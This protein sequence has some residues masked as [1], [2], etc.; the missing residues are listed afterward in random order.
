MAWSVLQSASAT[1]P[2][3]ISVAATFPNNVASG[4]KIIA[5]LSLSGTRTV[6]T[7]QDGSG[8]NLTQLAVV[9]NGTQQH[10][11]LYAM[12]TPAGD[13]G[14]KPTIT[15][16]FSAI[17]APS[18]LLI[19]EV[20]GLLA[21]NTSAMLDGTPGTAIGTSG[22]GSIGPPTFTD[23]A[24]NEYLVYL[25]G[26]D[27]G[28]LTYTP[29]AGYTADAN[30]VN[31]SST[32]NMV[33]SYKNSTGGTETGSYAISGTSC[34]WSVMMAAFQLA[35][36]GTAAPPVPQQPG[37]RNWRRRHRRH[38]QSPAAMLAVT[39]DAVGAG[40]ATAGVTSL[41]WSHTCRAGAALLVWVAVGAFPDT[42]F[43]VSGVTLDGTTNFTALG[44]PVHD[45][46]GS[47]AGFGQ[48]F[49]LTGVAAGAHTIAVTVSGGTP[50]SIEGNSVS[51][52]NAGSFGTPQ[53][54]GTGTGQTTATLTHTGS[55][56]TSVVAF[57]AASGH[58]LTAPTLVSRWAANVDTN[59]GAGNAAIQDI[60]GGGSLTGKWTIV[61]DA[62]LIQA[63][64]ITLAGT[65]TV[66]SGTAAL[67]GA[68]SMSASGVF[69]G[70]AGL[71]GQG[72]LTAAGAFAGA[73]ALSGSGSM[74]ASGAFAG[75]A[76]LSGAGSMSGTGVRTAAGSAAL[77]GTG[78][79]TATGAFAGSALLSGSGSLSATGLV[80]VPGAATLSGTG[81][82]TA[83]GAFAGS[84]PLAGTGTMTAAGSKTVPGAAVLAG[85]GIM[86]ATGA[87]AGAANLAGTGTL[88]ATGSKR[89]PGVA[90]MAGTG[91]MT[92]TGAFAGVSALAGTGT[93]S[94]TGVRTAAGAAI[95]AGV[96]SMTA[97]GV[98]AGSAALAGTGTMTAT[99]Q[100]AGAFSGTA[101]LAGAGSLTA[102]GAVI[103]VGTAPLSGS[104]A[105]SAAW[106]L[107]GTA[108][109]SG[110]G[111]MTAAGTRILH[112]T[113]A[114]AGIGS[115][116]AAG[117]VGMPFFGVAL[118]SGS[119][120][121]T[122]QTASPR[123][124]DDTLLGGSAV[125]VVVFA[126]TITADTFQAG[127][128]L[129]AWIY[130]GAVAASQ[131]YAG[132]GSPALLYG[133]SAS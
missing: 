34:Q 5:A 40:Q 26:D 25:Y 106:L 31:S 132:S 56:A 60:P 80:V 125:A 8:N 65:V 72:S 69:A 98:F 53:T 94:A 47:A 115:L 91:T 79:M 24:A 81:I 15:V 49:A 4:T 41:S 122:G 29:P 58:P 107:A 128:I 20:S 44:S 92:A 63:V 17:N 93:L 133:G 114:L 96:G 14:T 36:A 62:Y 129:P 78:T 1:N 7:V 86:T 23:T 57:G 22:S 28:P 18:S 117:T 130:D 42:A 119:G 45:N 55:A 51:Y 74:S 105:M 88:T 35:A 3:A 2:A 59:T 13:V 9:A 110:T 52:L 102:T 120:T 16:T 38:Q 33:T 75:T 123:P 121:M 101:T 67:D 104:G 97:A 116:S 127:V 85:T 54:V 77:A 37:N 30:G 61:S 68:G 76:P 10:T 118:L 43:A 21:G 103:R 108:T 70:T 111:S 71:D 131:S 50:D 66:H 48:W 12:D 89:V 64:E 46:A 32:A 39:F 82:M 126:G 100:I 27:G 84:A 112:V 90:A 109:L 83:A 87:F 113:I 73:A 11:F 19:Q 6:S 124:L 95:L 99:G